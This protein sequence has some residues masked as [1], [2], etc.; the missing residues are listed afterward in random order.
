MPNRKVELADL[1]KVTHTRF[2]KNIVVPEQ[3]GLPDV[4]LPKTIKDRFGNTLG[5]VTDSVDNQLTLSRELIRKRSVLERQLSAGGDDATIRSDFERLAHRRIQLRRLRLVTL[6]ARSAAY[7]AHALS[8][9]IRPPIGENVLALSVSEH[10][11]QEADHT[12]TGDSI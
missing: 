6:E 12:N 5:A 3:V 4:A 10:A 11:H 1:F 7:V 9:R 8:V 2:V